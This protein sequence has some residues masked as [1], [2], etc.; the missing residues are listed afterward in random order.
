MLH[1]TLHHVTIKA[2]RCHFKKTRKFVGV[3][4]YRNLKDTNKTIKSYKIEKKKKRQSTVEN[5]ND[6]HVKGYYRHKES[7]IKKA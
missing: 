3:Q 4:W 5:E 7:L 1:I 6:N 2:S